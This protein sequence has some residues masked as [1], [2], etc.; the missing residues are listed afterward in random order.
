MDDSNIIEVPED[1]NPEEGTAG[2][3]FN[4]MTPEEQQ[5]LL[6]QIQASM[7]RSQFF[8]SK[9]HRARELRLYHRHFSPK[10]RRRKKLRRQTAHA[11]RKQNYIFAKSR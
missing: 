9:H 11:S 4:S 10:A 3:G 5:E 8:Q 1:G 2:E 7:V 6:K